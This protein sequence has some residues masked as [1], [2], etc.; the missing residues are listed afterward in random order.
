MRCPYC[1]Y[2]DSRVVDSR[3]VNDGV[4]RRRQCLNCDSRFTTYERVQPASFLVMKKDGRREEFDR[5][6]LA[7]GIR[8]ACAKRSIANEEIERVVDRVEEELHSMGRVEVP[9]V[10]VGA[11]VMQYLRDLDRVAYIR[12]ASVYREFA[13]AESFKEEV[14]ALADRVGRV[15]VG[16]LP[17][18][19]AADLVTVG[20]GRMRAGKTRKGGND[21]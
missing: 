12:F 10:T 5:D 9:S 13:D 17:L 4:R 19:S 21:V 16:Q 20:K 7:R 15:I 14:D 2:D 18:I 11:L 6:K 8:I 1:G 3:S